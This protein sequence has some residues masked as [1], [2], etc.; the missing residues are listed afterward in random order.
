MQK[1][2]KINLMFILRR[3]NF[4]FAIIFSSIYLLK[5]IPYSV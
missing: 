4:V 1:K 3:K 2:K 5:P